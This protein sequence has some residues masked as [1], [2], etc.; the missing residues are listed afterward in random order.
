MS[1][2]EL[3][4]VNSCGAMERAIMNKFLFIFILCSVWSMTAYAEEAVSVREKEF[5]AGLE[6]A[7]KIATDSKKKTD[8]I[9]RGT[10]PLN[11]P[12]I[13]SSSE[14]NAAN[15]IS[16]RSRI[17]EKKIYNYFWQDDKGEVIGSAS[18]IDKIDLNYLDKAYINYNDGSREHL[19]GFEYKYI[20]D[21]IDKYVWWVLLAGL[22]LSALSSKKS[23]MNKPLAFLGLGIVILSIVSCFASSNIKYKNGESNIAQIQRNERNKPHPIETNLEH[24]IRRLGR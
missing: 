4:S 10:L 17:E 11:T 18:S 14:N 1:E 12:P 16:A 9:E 8:S 6:R 13:T 24:E 7:A 22:V 20:S 23:G 2:Y 5:K 21:R 3:Y 19:K 15:Q